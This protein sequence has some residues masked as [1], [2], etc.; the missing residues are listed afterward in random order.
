MY[1][2]P[3]GYIRFY[4]DVRLDDSYT[5]TIY[6]A[7][8][9]ERDKWFID[10]KQVG[11]IDNMSYMR[12]GAGIIMVEKPISYFNNINYMSFT[13]SSFENMTYYCFINTVEYV[14]NTTTRIIYTIDDMITYFPYL[15]WRKSFIVRRHTPNDIIGNNTQYEDVNCG[16]NLDLS[17]IS[18]ATGGQLPDMTTMVPIA[19][20]LFKKDVS[21]Q[22]DVINFNGVYQGLE[23]LR[24]DSTT[25]LRTWLEQMVDAGNSND[26]VSMFMFPASMYDRDGTTRDYFFTFAR[27]T[28]LEGYVPKNKKLLTYP[29]TFLYASTGEGNSAN[30]KFELSYTGEIGFRLVGSVSGIA[31]ISAIPYNYR[32]LSL[33]IDSQLTMNNYPQCSWIIDTYRSY[34]ALNQNTL[35]NYYSE[36]VPL[37]MQKAITTRDVSNV[38][39]GIAALGAVGSLLSLNPLSAASGAAG[40]YSTYKQGQ[41]AMK[42]VQAQVSQ[43]MAQQKDLEARPPQ[44][45]GNVS[46]STNVAYGQKKIHFY[47]ASIKKEYAERIDDYFELF[48]YAENRFIIPKFDARPVWTYMKMLYPNCSGN[49]P[50][51]VLT[52]IKNIMENGIRFWKSGNSIG[53]YTLNNH[54]GVPS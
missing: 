45:G 1:I 19:V 5:D 41:F 44:M 11:I 29:Y 6:F 49:V 7:S 22:A 42:D 25:E 8:V 33:D 52:H 31:S 30:Y 18:A 12:K 32:G 16:E 15:T 4:R 24:F 23:Y 3:D 53:N 36:Q 27:P 34:L 2:V 14:S 39:A 21:K 26:I 13:N 28:S 40:A 43:F 37:M 17:E 9:E 35:N 50:D 51:D 48:G 20:S 47:Y 10:N 38:N 46:T 54:E